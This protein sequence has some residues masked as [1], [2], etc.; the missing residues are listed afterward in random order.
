MNEESPSTESLKPA[1]TPDPATSDPQAAHAELAELK[2]RHLRLAADFENYKRRARED[3]DRRAS[4]QRDEL[5]KDLL[6][7]LDNLR[8]ALESATNDASPLRAGVE[9]TLQ[10]FRQVLHQH[11]CQPDECL[12]QVF[13]P[14]RQEA[15]GSRHDPS[16]ADHV[17]LE[18]VQEGWLRDGELLRPAKVIINDLAATADTCPSQTDQGKNEHTS[19]PNESK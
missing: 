17:V 14:R 7:V 10:Q 19:T 2:D 18:I 3:A 16:L 4:G 5:L 9:L 15:I 12:D 1:N 8:R 6:P 11:G 13:D